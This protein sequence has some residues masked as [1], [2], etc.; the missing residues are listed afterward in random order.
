VEKLWSNFGVTSEKADRLNN[1]EFDES[2]FHTHKAK[3]SN[4]FENL[5]RFCLINH[6]YCPLRSVYPLRGKND[7]NYGF[8]LQYFIAYGEFRVADKVL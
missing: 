4:Y 5:C 6:S 7:I 2:F 1:S 3:L 8:V